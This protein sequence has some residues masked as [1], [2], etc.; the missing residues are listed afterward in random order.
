[1]ASSDTS[2]KYNVIKSIVKNYYVRMEF[3]LKLFY[4]PFNLHYILWKILYFI[5]YFIS[6]SNRKK[7]KLDDILKFAFLVKIWAFLD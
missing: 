7:Q 1:M 6:L 4:Q 5:N 2:Q 3:H